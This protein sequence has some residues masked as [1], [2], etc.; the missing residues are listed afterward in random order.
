MA[1]KLKPNDPRVK[2][3]TKQIRGKTYSYILGEPEGTKVDTIFLVH[4]WPDLA[5]GWRNQIP[6]LMSL[7]YQVVAPNLVGYAGTDAPQDLKQYSFKSVSDDLAELARE[8]VGV[9]GQ[10]VLGGHDWGGLQVWRTA[11]YYPKLIKA[12][13]SVC[14]PLLPL[15]KEYIPLEDIIAAGHLQNF[16]YHL[17]LKGPDVEAHVTGKEKIRQFFRALY[18]G[19]T[20]DKEP[21]FTMDRGLHIDILD[22]IEHPPL[23]DA[24]ELEYY[25]EQYSLQKAPELRGP[26]NWYRTREINA[27]EEIELAK[28][29]PSRFE[30][31]SLFIAATHDAALPP[32][33]S[34]GMEAAYADLTRAEV[35]A[36]HWALTEAAHEVNDHIGKWLDKVNG[37]PKL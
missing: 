30:M 1:T 3:E 29:P 21:G 36:T 19:R 9:D 34:Q 20:P 8:F 7:G 27:N 28:E 2:Y 25:V 12:V 6:Y 24:D 5:F 35:N 16:K 37:T 11:Y 4:G 14:T 32:A 18:L 33:L 23:L 10:I 13:F 31:P 26:L 22:K 15:S 17:Q